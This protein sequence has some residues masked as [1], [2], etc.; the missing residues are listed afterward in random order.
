VLSQ[1]LKIVRVK[2]VEVH[3]FSGRPVYFSRRRDLRFGHRSS[4]AERGDE[5]SRPVPACLA[6]D[7]CPSAFQS[8]PSIHDW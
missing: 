6:N 4:L 5:Y 3:F 7:L 2:R 8:T 1:P